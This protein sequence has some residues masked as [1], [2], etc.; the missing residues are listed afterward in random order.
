MG[1]GS[2][3]R[4]GLPGTSFRWSAGTTSGWTAETVIG[5]LTFSSAGKVL[6]IGGE[7]SRVRRWDLGTGDELPSIPVAGKSVLALAF[8][9]DGKLL[10]TGRNGRATRL[11]EVATGKV[12]RDL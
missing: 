2:S 5:C 12:V 1:R 4:S 3:N 9:P 6:A 8:S 7:G 11:T 10:V